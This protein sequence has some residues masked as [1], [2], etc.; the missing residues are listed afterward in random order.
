MSKITIYSE[1][2]NKVDGFRAMGEEFIRK[3]VINGKSRS[4]HENYLRQISK[5][6]LY[7]KRSPLEIEA[8]EL[9][10]YLYYLIQRDTDAQSS[11]KHLIYG[12]RKLYYLFDKEPYWLRYQG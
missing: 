10:E 2:C 8:D 3:L 9:E 6:A 1:A 7:Y 4:T 5:L 12:L 11:Y